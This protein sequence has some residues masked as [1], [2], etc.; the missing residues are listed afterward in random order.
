MLATINVFPK[1]LQGA[2][3]PIKLILSDGITA[4]TGST[5]L[6]VEDAVFTQKIAGIVISVMQYTFNNTFTKGQNNFELANKIYVDMTQIYNEY[7]YNSGATTQNATSQNL[8]NKPIRNK[9]NRIFKINK[10]PNYYKLLAAQ[11]A[12]DNRQYGVAITSAQD[13]ENTALK[14]TLQMAS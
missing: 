13:A 12:F 6:V 8:L 7:A 3:Y 4:V 11:S 9:K 10:L 2:P 5:N 1:Y 14:K